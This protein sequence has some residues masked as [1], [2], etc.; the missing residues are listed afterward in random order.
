MHV[1]PT[2]D[3]RFNILIKKD[4]ETPKQYPRNYAEIKKN[5]L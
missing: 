4:K 1:L 5:P 2:G 3:E